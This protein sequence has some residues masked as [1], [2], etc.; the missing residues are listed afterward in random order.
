MRAALIYAHAADDSDR[1]I[2]DRLDEM[3]ATDAAPARYLRAL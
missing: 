1:V 2:A 3:F